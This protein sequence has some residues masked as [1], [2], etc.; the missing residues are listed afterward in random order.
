MYFNNLGSDP[1]S[2]KT[3]FFRWHHPSTVR[4]GLLGLYTSCFTLSAFFVFFFLPVKR[5][6]RFPSL[7]VPWGSSVLCTTLDSVLELSSISS[8]SKALLF[9]LFIV[10]SLL[11]MSDSQLSYQTSFSVTLSKLINQCSGGGEKYTKMHRLDHYF[12]VQGQHYG[13]S[14]F[15]HY[16]HRVCLCRWELEGPHEVLKRRM[17]NN[18]TDR[19]QNA[20]TWPRP[21]SGS[22]PALSL[23]PCF[24]L[25][26]ET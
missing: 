12:L 18:V 1:L 13:Q 24:V 3:T 21:W 20:H 4:A 2:L 23:T 6:P 10:T 9:V 26:I 22:Y 19:R 7:H 8:E 15:H 25:P 5:R 16:K 14:A 17:I 11:L